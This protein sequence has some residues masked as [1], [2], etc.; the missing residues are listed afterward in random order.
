M[1]QK[2]S[3]DSTKNSELH[4]KG[5]PTYMSILLLVDICGVM[6]KNVTEWSTSELDGEQWNAERNGAKRTSVQFGS[7]E[8][9]CHQ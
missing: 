4:Q 7:Y 5:I 3:G 1:N 6:E 9:L 8:Q 2:L